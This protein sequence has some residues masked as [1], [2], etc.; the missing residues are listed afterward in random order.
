M[1]L[2]LSNVLTKEETQA[3]EHEL[4]NAD[5]IL[6]S[7]TAGHIAKQVK[8]NLQLEQSNPIAKKL[9]DFLLSKLALHP[10]FQGAAL[11]AKI[12]PP[13]F[14][15]YQGGGT[16]GDHIDNAIRFHPEHGYPI[17]TDV[18]ITVFLNEPEQYEGGEL[19]IQDTYGEKKVK[20]N[21][22]DA[23]LYP[24]TS[25]HQVTPVKKGRRLASFFWIQSLVPQAEQRSQLYQLDQS[26]QALTKTLEEHP[27]ITRL[28]G[29]YHNLLRLWSQP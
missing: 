16:F 2:T 7:N 3:F 13:M 19:I 18:S 5:W 4:E 14:N 12:L 1:L 25:L 15:C 26:I 22:G 9:G 11:P 28:S 8:S 20:L 6:G 17:R 21:A 10:E 29:I 23:V 24:S 27:E